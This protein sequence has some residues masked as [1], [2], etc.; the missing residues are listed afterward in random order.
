MRA[1]ARQRGAGGVKSLS[2]LEK[3]IP[4]VQALGRRHS[5]YGVTAQHYSTVGEALLWT[6]EQG[7]GQAFDS[8]MREAWTATYT[9]LARTMQAAAEEATEVVAA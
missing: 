3:L 9:V 7:L 2:D 4:A 8:E 6:L 5:S 1:R